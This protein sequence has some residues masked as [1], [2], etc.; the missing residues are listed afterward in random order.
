MRTNS[1]TTPAGLI[2]A[3]ALSMLVASG[4]APGRCAETKAGLLYRLT[5][6]SPTRVAGQAATAAKENPTE[7]TQLALDLAFYAWAS[8]LSGVPTDFPRAD[9]VVGALASALVDPTI[10]WA[11]DYFSSGSADETDRALPSRDD[12]RVQELLDLKTQFKAAVAYKESSPIKAVNALQEAARLCQKLYLDM[13]E[14][15]MLRLLGD[16]YCY[17]LA[18]YR[19][20][21]A[22]YERAAWTLGAYRCRAAVAAIHDDWGTVSMQLAKYANATEHFTEA[23]RQWEQLA[24]KDPSRFRYRDLAGREYMKAGEAQMAAGDTTGALELMRTKGLTHLQNWAEAT[25]S[26]EPLVRSLVKVAE[27]RRALG[28]P[29][30][31]LGLLKQAQRACERQGDPV[32]TAAVY[33]ELCKTYAALNQRA[34][35]NAAAAKRTRILKDAAVAGDLAAAKLAK[36]G[37]AEASL[38]LV[39]SAERGAIAYQE[40]GAYTRS[41][42]LWQGL[43]DYYRKTGSIDDQLRCMR[44]LGAFLELD[45]RSREALQVRLQAVTLARTA[46]QSALAAEIVQDVVQSFISVGDVSNALEGLKELVPIVEE[47]G[48]MRGAARVLESRAALLVENKSY[49]AA[50]ADYASARARYL[51]QVGDAWSAAQVALKL[52]ETQRMAGQ[53]DESRATLEGAIRDIES[54]YGPE[55]S[56]IDA[57]EFGSSIIAALYRALAAAYVHDGRPDAAG[58][59]FRK[60]RKYDWFARTV[61]EMRSDASDPETAAW[62]GAIDVMPTDG[63]FPQSEGPGDRLLGDDCGAFVQSCWWLERQYP[64]EYN[65]LPID[66]LVLAKSRTRMP[67]GLLAV[68]FLTTDSSLYAFVCGRDRSVCR[69]I[70]IGRNAIDAAVNRLRRTLRNCEESLSAGIPI[71]PITDWRESSFLEIKEPLAALYAQLV[72][73]IRETLSGHSGLVFV[74][75]N[76]L[77]GLPMHALI[78]SETESGPVFLVQEYRISYLARNMLDSLIGESARSVD[79]KSDWVCIFADPEA[80]LPG[81]QKE[82]ASV[83]NAYIT[84][85][86][87]V[88]PDRATATN[89]LKELRQGGVIH[90]AAHHRID[91][92]PSGFE[93]LLAPD[94][95]SD[96]AL[97]AQELLKI[98]NPNLQ[99]VTLSACDSI[100]SSDPISSGPARAA[101]LFSLVGAQSVLGGL[102]K[103]SD[104]AASVVMGEFYR[105]LSRGKPRAEALQRALLSVIE[106]KRYAHPFYWACFALYGNPK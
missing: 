54:S 3:L 43:A 1:I 96:G 62:A 31:S 98:H 84:S 25:K 104:E 68:E 35:Q 27:I 24:N 63:P 45:K 49:E 47:S 26:Y 44:T 85:R 89:F 83:K 105:D 99:L 79:P 58:E 57:G 21:E 6:A 69:Q 77:A 102:W 10:R 66:P 11:V 71:P 101:E 86:W 81:A 72:A 59:L 87:Y 19:A 33:E 32:L 51:T 64:R 2:P 70:G 74:L 65:M 91:P 106:S 8:R 14:A 5:Q 30:D 56:L 94:R 34:N 23:A 37:S 28:D 97:G 55:G 75:P 53:A 20:A 78:S 103:V 46:R 15:L 18:R 36:A 38:P 93:L 60:A 90:V 9:A 100:G 29:A 73:P 13:S 12:Q 67:D 48:S 82:A 76:D 4:L 42:E 52:A 92:N 17:D 50:I 40:L 61:S 80:N 41:A 7:T 95:D 22:C 39:K 88:G 16:H